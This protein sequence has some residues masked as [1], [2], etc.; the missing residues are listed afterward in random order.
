MSNC[1]SL[2]ELKFRHKLANKII[3]VIQV[4]FGNSP[5]A[6]DAVKHYEKQVKKLDI[7]IVECYGEDIP[8]TIVKLKTANLF[9]KGDTRDG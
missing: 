2:N 5:E 4:E 1:R 9:G 8:P 6:L 3:R 7:E